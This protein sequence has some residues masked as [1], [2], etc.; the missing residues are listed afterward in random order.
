M[1]IDVLE[2]KVLFKCTYINA[3]LKDEVNIRHLLFQMPTNTQNTVIL[4]KSCIENFVETHR[5][6][7]IPGEWPETL[8]KFHKI[9]TPEN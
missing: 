8:R 9:S 7:R 2:N 3:E 1:P 6:R 4:L 5:I